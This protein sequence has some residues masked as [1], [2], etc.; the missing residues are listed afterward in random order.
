MVLAK[1]AQR[2]Q[3]AKVVRPRVI[4][5]YG[6]RIGHFTSGF[7][8]P[9]GSHGEWNRGRKDKVLRVRR[10]FGHGPGDFGLVGGQAVVTVGGERD[11]LIAVALAD[12]GIRVK[13]NEVVRLAEPLQVGQRYL[14]DYARRPAA[15]RTQNI[16][17]A[18]VAQPGAAGIVFRSAPTDSDPLATDTA[19]RSAMRSGALPRAESACSLPRTRCTAL[20]TPSAPRRIM[21][22]QLVLICA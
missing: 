12:Y 7:A 2:P 17:L 4:R 10:R 1:L 14:R 16:E 19:S 6:K 3:A 21:P 5:V 8:A 20:P 13:V 9:N 15:G 22:I 18:Q 11:D